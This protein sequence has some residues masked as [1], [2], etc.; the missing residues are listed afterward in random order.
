MAGLPRLPF[1]RERWSRRR[2]REPF[3]AFCAARNKRKRTEAPPASSASSSHV[4]RVATRVA[5]PSWIGLALGVIE[6]FGA[7]GFFGVAMNWRG[8]D[9]REVTPLCPVV[10][11]PAHEIREVGRPGARAE[12]ALHE[13]RRDLRGR[14]GAFYQNIRRNLLSS[15]L[16]I[17]VLAPAV[18]PVLEP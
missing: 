4:S 6:T 17:D 3:C 12:L 18:L 9:D 1:I 16:A 5:L 13:Q 15:A 7:A 10:V 8:L 11:T 14:L 2:W